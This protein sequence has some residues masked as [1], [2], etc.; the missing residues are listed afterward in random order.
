M[1]NVDYSEVRNI[2][3]IHNKVNIYPHGLLVYKWTSVVKG[4]MYQ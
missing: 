3:S 1:S 4:L 2:I